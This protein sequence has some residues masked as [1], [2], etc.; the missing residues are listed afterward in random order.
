[1]RVKTFTD[2]GKSRCFCK[3]CNNTEK[4]TN[5]YIM[6]SRSK[7]SNYYGYCKTCFKSRKRGEYGQ[8]LEARLRR[9]R[10]E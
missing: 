3:G 4:L 7:N 8:G 5:N 2:N 6:F 10:G 9:Q 1:M